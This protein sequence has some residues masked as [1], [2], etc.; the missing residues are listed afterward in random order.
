MNNQNTKITALVIT[1]NEEKNINELLQNLDFADE[2]IVVDS[3]STDRTLSLIRNFENVKVYQHKFE[4]FS[5]QRNIALS[6]AKNEWVL[7][8][9]ADERITDDLKNEILS[10]VAN[11]TMNGFYIKRKFYFFNT[12]VRFSGLQND[13]NLRLFKKTDAKY[14]GIVHEKLNLK[15]NIGTLSHFLIHHSYTDHIHFKEKVFYYNR[16]KAV[17]KAEKNKK[18]SSFFHVF[19]PIYTFLN[20]YFLRLGILDGKKGFT[21]CKI[22]A[23]G[24]AERYKELKILNKKQGL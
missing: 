1:L 10:N 24:I 8:I 5:T 20:R 14:S 18:Y 4:D 19:H 17:E 12:A 16:L 7:F 21:I 13:K 22:Y 9:D 3:L 11:T 23:Q 6:Y 15:T 2:I